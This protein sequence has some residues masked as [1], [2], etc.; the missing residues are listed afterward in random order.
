MKKILFAVSIL[1]ALNVQAQ[2][3]LPDFSVSTRGK[4]KSII[5]WTNAYPKVT[6]ISIQRSFDSLRNYKTILTVP[7]PHVP[8]N[9][10]V[11]SKA[12]TDFQFYRLFIVLDSGRYLFS[13]ARRPTWDT[14]KLATPPLPPKKD[15]TTRIIT[16]IPKTD[17]NLVNKDSSANTESP[18]VPP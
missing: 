7:D 16:E 17:S 6:Q 12:P 5:S 3:I 18:K 11:D 9:G 13:K 1:L 10:F 15:E 8:Q 4:G 14:S 2:N